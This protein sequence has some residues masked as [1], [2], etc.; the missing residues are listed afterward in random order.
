MMLQHLFAPLQKKETG[1][2]E[3]AED[4]VRHSL[5]ITETEALEKSD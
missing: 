5:S 1:I 3:W 2:L 4:A